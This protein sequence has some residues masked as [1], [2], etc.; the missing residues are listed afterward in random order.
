MC[1]KLPDYMS[2][3]KWCTDIKIGQP[4]NWIRTDISTGVNNVVCSFGDHGSK[5]SV[6]R[7][8]QNRRRLQMWP[9]FDYRLHVLCDN[10][11]GK[12]RYRYFTQE[13]MSNNLANW[14]GWNSIYHLT[15]YNETNFRNYG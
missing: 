7:P 9:I 8:N 10:A 2:G 11:N 4:F 3:I 15:S 5:K 6:W 12:S 13:K 1:I 14:L